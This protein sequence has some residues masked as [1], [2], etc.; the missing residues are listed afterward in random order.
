MKILVTGAD[1]QVGSDL[2]TQGIS[3]GFT[4]DAT[5]RQQLDITD[6]EQVNSYIEENRPDLV[7]NAAA[8]TAVDKAEQDKERAYLVNSQG[9]GNLAEAC[10]QYDIPIFHISTDYVFNGK[11]KQSYIESQS[12]SPAS[13]YGAS[14]LEGEEKVKLWDKHIILRVAWVFGEH[15]NNFVKT[16]IRLAKERYEL[17]IVNDQIGGP[18][19]SGDIA[20]VLLTLARIYQEK[21]AIDWGT[22][23][24]TGT[25]NVSWFQFAEAI[26]VQAEE[27][28]LLM[29]APMLTP[30]TTE[31][32][33]TPVTR[34][35]NSTLDCH[36]LYHNFGI[37]Q[38][39]WHVGLLQVIN[40]WKTQ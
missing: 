18:T 8:Y 40:A 7:I 16:M 36:K 5:N 11:Q 25:P 13:V 15:G 3:K 6:Q 1:G 29:G 38:P 10:S 23:H 31:E 2:V 26:F 27:S 22:Y 21:R 39:D 14:K 35:E 30:I 19:W 20:N 17:N 24:Y 4:I 28:K 12:P 34:P 9:A 33:P 32:Y 37:S